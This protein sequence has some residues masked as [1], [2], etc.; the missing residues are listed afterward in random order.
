MLVRIGFYISHS[1]DIYLLCTICESIYVNF[2][3][4]KDCFLEND[5]RKFNF[6]LCFASKSFINATNFSTPSIGIAL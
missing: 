6:Y 4:Q 2:N 5:F 1:M 3:E